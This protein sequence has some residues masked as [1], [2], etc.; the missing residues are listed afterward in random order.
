[1]YKR[2][3]KYPEYQPIYEPLLLTPDS[4]TPAGYRTKSLNSAKFPRLYHNGAVLLPDGRVL[5]IGGNANRAAVEKDGTIHVDV[6]GDPKTFF[7]IPEL[8]N[9]AGEVEPFDIDTFYQD[10]Q[11]YYAGQD[12]EPF[13]PAEIWQG[14]IFSP[15]LLYTSPSPRD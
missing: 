10:P 8:H 4:Q 3:G 1:M 11:H 9:K 12:P 6:L 15:C 14:E 13:V 5:V 7:R 2:Q